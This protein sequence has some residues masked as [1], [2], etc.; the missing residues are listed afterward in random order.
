[1]HNVA[2]KAHGHC[3][4]TVKASCIPEPPDDINQAQAL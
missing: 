1:M 2:K 4:V 3:T